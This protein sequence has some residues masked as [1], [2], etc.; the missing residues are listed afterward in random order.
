MIAKTC[1]PYSVFYPSERSPPNPK[2]EGECPVPSISIIITTHKLPQFSHHH[3]KQ[4]TPPKKEKRK[5]LFNPPLPSIHASTKI[6]ADRNRKLGK[7][8]RK[9]PTLQNRCSVARAPAPSSSLGGDDGQHG[10]VFGSRAA[11]QGGKREEKGWGK[12]LL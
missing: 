4:T 3:T 5:I 12:G 11:A 7:L 10:C 1:T 9:R 6:P 2:Q 8:E